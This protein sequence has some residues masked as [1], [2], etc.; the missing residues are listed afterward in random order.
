MI[1]SQIINIGLGII[2]VIISL[3]SYYFYIRSKIAGAAAGA[4]DDA[5]QVDK[6]GEEKLELATEQVYALV[7]IMLK[8]FITKDFVRQLVQEAFNKIE[9]YARKQKK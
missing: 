8:G 4:I 3:L 7:P 5:E 1:E 9:D 6:T 2:A